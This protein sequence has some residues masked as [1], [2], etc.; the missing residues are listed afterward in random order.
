MAYWMQLLAVIAIAN[1]INLEPE[2]QAVADED[3][4][5]STSGKFFYIDFRTGD[6]LG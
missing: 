1:A 6:K 5:P 4:L 2:V 3:G